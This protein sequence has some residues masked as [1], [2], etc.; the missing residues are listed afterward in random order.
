MDGHFL[1][2]CTTNGFH[3]NNL[4]GCTCSGALQCAEPIL[5]A[6]SVPMYCHAITY[7][8]RL[9]KIIYAKIKI[10]TNSNI[11][12]VNR[13]L[14]AAVNQLADKCRLRYRLLVHLKRLCSKHCV[15]RSDCSSSSLIS[16]HTVCLFA[17]MRPWCK[18]LHAADDFSRRLFQ[19]PDQKS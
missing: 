8:Q 19:M 7:C 6:D 13:Y 4:T 16:V 5:N 1:F 11:W 15:A 18:Y 2:K 9:G 14:P 3:F 12:F 10:A 17:E